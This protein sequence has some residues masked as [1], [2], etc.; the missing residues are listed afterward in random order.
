V[1]VLQE[2]TNLGPIVDFEVVDLD[3]I[4]QPQLVACCNNGRYGSLRL[5]RNGIGINEQASIELTGPHLSCALQARA[6]VRGPTRTSD[7]AQALFHGVHIGM[8]CASTSGQCPAP[9]G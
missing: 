5:I 9:C 8:Q 6:T 7:H 4:G 1:Q 2:F 3:K